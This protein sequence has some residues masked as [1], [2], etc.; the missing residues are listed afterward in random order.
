MESPAIVVAVLLSKAGTKP[1]FHSLKPALHDAFLGRSVLLLVGALI[2][3]WIS[4]PPGL[5]SVE[6][7]FVTPFFGVIALFLLVLLLANS[8][9]G[10]SDA[11]VGIKS[12]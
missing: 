7:L 10:A 9:A 4:G 8:W 11:K 6:G 5:K 2:V 3:G 1:S 12:R